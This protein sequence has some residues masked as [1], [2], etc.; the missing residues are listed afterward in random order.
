VLAAHCAKATE[1]NLL[2]LPEHEL[3]EASCSICLVPTLTV[4]DET[5]AMSLSYSSR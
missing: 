4:V 3:D 2:I 5:R 1:I